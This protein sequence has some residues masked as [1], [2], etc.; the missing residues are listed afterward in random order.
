MTTMKQNKYEESS[1]L[2]GLSEDLFL[3][4]LL[5]LPLKS[6]GRFKSVCKSWLSVISN[7]EFARLHLQSSNL[8]TSNPRSML[9][10]QKHNMVSLFKFKSSTDITKGVDLIPLNQQFVDVFL[11]GSC[12]IVGSCDGIVC[13]YIKSQEKCGEDLLHLWNPTTNENKQISLP[14]DQGL[15]YVHVDSSWFGYIPSLKDYMIFLVNT[16]IRGKPAF[17]KRMYIYSFRNPKWRELHVT[18]ED[19]SFALGSNSIFMNE[20]LH[21]LVG[22]KFIHKFDLVAETFERVPFSIKLDLL[23]KPHQIMLDVIG[24]KNGLCARFMHRSE[25]GEWMFE[26]W[27]LEEYNKWNSWKKLYRIDLKKEIARNITRLLG[28]TYNGNLF[29][30]EKN[31]LTVIDPSQNPHLPIIVCRATVFTV[32]DYVESLISPFYFA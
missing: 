31:A 30:R 20:A 32:T 19:L 2:M 14:G 18:H 4:I 25:I 17:V 3:E 1:L 26:L 10:L 9:T 24:E 12:F 11:G 28:F 15:T 23:P 6:L 29:I 13:L 21:C 5:R 22:R 16:N 8:A 27:M 7:P